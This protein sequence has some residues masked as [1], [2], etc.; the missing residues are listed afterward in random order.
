MST[1][2]LRENGGKDLF[3]KF[4]GIV[5]VRDDPQER[6]RIIAN[7]P[8]ID[9]DFYTKWAGSYGIPHKDVVVPEIGELV[10]IEFVNG[11]VNQPLWTF[12]PI[13]TR[14]IVDEL[15]SVPIDNNLPGRRIIGGEKGAELILE[16]TRG[17]ESAYLKIPSS[18]E[19][20]IDNKI[21]VGKESQSI[22]VIG[23]NDG[24]IQ[25]GGNLYI[26]SDGSYDVDIFGNELKVVG[27][28][29]AISISGEYEFSAG[30]SI[31]CGAGEEYIINAGELISYN[32]LNATFQE[33]AT[34]DL[35]KSVTQEG[36]INI[37]VKNAGQIEGNITLKAT[38]TGTELEINTV[39]KINIVAKQ[40]DVSVQSETGKVI[41]EGLSTTGTVG[42]I[43]VLTGYT[44][45]RF[46]GTPFGPAAPGGSSSSVEGSG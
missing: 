25:L 32:V 19:N 36:I 18:I 6:K 28:S 1:T 31:V 22:F 3:G 24:L 5:A 34:I 45:D 12:G 33:V 30:K 7:V 42:T 43:G 37:V 13:T 16:S 39:G 14:N 2:D 27:G 26:K 15:R 29:S 41:L 38:P 40:G 9:K 10:C 21:G 20:G 11:D 23:E 17:T 8:Q 35:S 44:I 46:T 4:Y